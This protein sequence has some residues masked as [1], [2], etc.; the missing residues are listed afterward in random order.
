MFKMKVQNFFVVFQRPV[1]IIRSLMNEQLRLSGM[2][3]IERS[4]ISTNAAPAIFRMIMY[5]MARRFGSFI[6]GRH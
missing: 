5:V 4:N 3:I 6:Q 2:N 1:Q